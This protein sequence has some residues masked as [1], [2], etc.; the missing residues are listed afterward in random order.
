MASDISNDFSIRPFN[1]LDQLEDLTMME[2]VTS[3][4][5]HDHNNYFFVSH[6]MWHIN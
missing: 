6:V 1:V 5:L 3:D 2:N 4:D